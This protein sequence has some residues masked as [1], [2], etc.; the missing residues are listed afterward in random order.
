MKMPRSV[1]LAFTGIVALAGFALAARVAAEGQAAPASGKTAGQ[2]FKNVTTTGLKDL[3]V[4]DFIASMGV[5][6]A[7]LGLDCADCHPNAGTDTADFVVDN[8]R[9]NTT[10]RMVDM[11]ASINRTNFNGQQLVTCFTCHH[12]RITP[13][14]TVALDSWY[15][16]PN[17]ENDDLVRAQS[18]LPTADQVLDKY[19]EALGGAQK[20]AAITSVVATGTAVGYGE[21]GGSAEFSL[22]AKSPNQRTTLITYKDHPERGISTWI[23]DGRGGWIK[24]P[25]GL[26]AEYELNGGELDGARLEAQLSF[27]GQIKQVLSGWRARRHAE[28]RRSRL[29][30][31]PGHRSERLPCDVVFRSEIESAGQADPLYPFADRSHSDADRLRRLSGCR[32]REVSL[33]VQVHVAR[34]PVYG[35]AERR[36]NERSG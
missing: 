27:P 10:R 20:L 34:R 33:R 18:G 8:P 26:L 25:R 1:T 13:P 6:S 23:F 4:D 14:T 31:R 7:N 5:I 17:I 30:R 11:V 16:A 9:K 12:G 19:V 15:D 28:H 29:S 36:Q 2:A 21:L 3:S 32:R 35:E 22:F 24:T